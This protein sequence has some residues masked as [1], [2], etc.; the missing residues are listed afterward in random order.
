VKPCKIIV[1]VEVEVTNANAVLTEGRKVAVGP[2][3]TSRKAALM[4]ILHDRIDAAPGL[5]LS[6]MKATIVDWFEFDAVLD[7]R[8]PQYDGYREKTRHPS[9]TRASR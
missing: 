1:T 8:H 9:S 4:E 6:G 2:K 7:P 3:P 5:T